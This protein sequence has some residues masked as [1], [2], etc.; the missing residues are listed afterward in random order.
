MKGRLLAFVFLLAI[1][2]ALWAGVVA[3]QGDSPEPLLASQAPRPVL[4]AAREP[5]SDG[6]GVVAA[7]APFKFRI[8]P[9]ESL[10]KLLEDLGLGLQDA[11]SVTATLAEFIDFRRLRAGDEYTAYIGPDGET[12]AFE[13][14][15]DDRGEVRVTQVAGGEWV[16]RW[17]EF[18]REI[19]VRR[20]EGTL[21]ATL[22]GAIR[23]AGASPALAYA[24]AEALQWDLDFT[25]DL[26]LG[27]RFRVVFEQLFVD[28]E[29]R[30]PKRVLA[31]HYENR[32]K[33]YEAFRFGDDGG[34][35][36]AEGRPLKK[37]FLRSPLKFS[38]VTSQ[39]S[40]RRF[41]PVLKVYR[42]H[43]G[44]DYGAPKGTPVRATASGTV[45]TASWRGGGGRTVTLRHPND[46]Q[47]S[48]LHLSRFAKGIRS[49]QRVQQ[50]DVIG[51][52][53]STGLST[54]PH[55][56]YRIKHGGRWINPLSIKSVP[57]RPIAQQ[58]LPEFIAWRDSLRRSLDSGQ[59]LSEPQLA[60]ALPLPAEGSEPARSSSFPA[61]TT[62]R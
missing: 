41:H 48:Y 13:L 9:G 32:G 51:Y 59:P 49:G 10:G 28:G 55:L 5:P 21:V 42:P 54:G 2:G 46:Y 15:V 61:E 17:R 20:I 23:E 53:G 36:D 14:A 6:S 43:Y 62:S 3:F 22:E 33:A 52:V 24:M 19:E 11:R 58:D 60:Q 30:G 40:H 29:D 44:V 8:K 25:R 39:F 57:A 4:D 7:E 18:E 37:M 27:D 12:R 47:T 45:V 16:P 38:R 56:D 35:Y 31:L 26:R 50:G 34:F 1:F